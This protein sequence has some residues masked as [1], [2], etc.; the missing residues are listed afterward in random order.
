MTRSLI[1]GGT[2]YSHQTLR[3]LLGDLEGILE[4]LHE[5]QDKLKNSREQ[6]QVNGYWP[7]AF[8]EFRSLFNHSIRFYDTCIEEVTEIL[9]EIQT[10]VQQ[11]HV[12]Q[13]A[14]LSKTAKELNITFGRTWHNYFEEHEYSDPNFQVLDDMYSEGRQMAVDLLDLSNMAMRLSIFVG[15][16]PFL[17]PI[18]TTNASNLAHLRENL[19]E[20]FNVDE[21]KSLCQD[22]NV[23]Y[24]NLG[25]ETLQSNARELIN[26]C[27][28]RNA[29]DDLVARCQKLRPERYWSIQETTE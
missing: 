26:Y 24:D 8:V 29:L 25:G 11:H 17:R 3:D 10:E 7:T 1:P 27:Q 4:L 9:N 13:L 23:P 22:L 28:R 16:K 5:S 6:L 14:H 18:A 19:Q 21:L 12:D 15:K 20:S 2:D